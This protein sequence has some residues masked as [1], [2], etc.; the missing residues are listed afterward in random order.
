MKRTILVV[1][2]ACTEGLLPDYRVCGHCNGQAHYAVDRQ[3]DGTPPHPL[4]E[5]CPSLALQQRTLTARED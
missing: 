3:P 2:P 5:W 1:C 4:V